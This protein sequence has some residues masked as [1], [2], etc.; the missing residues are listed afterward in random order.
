MILLFFFLVS[1]CHETVSNTLPS[2]GAGG[3]HPGTDQM[4]PCQGSAGKVQLEA[5]TANTGSFSTRAVEQEPA[6]S[7]SALRH[8]PST[9]FGKRKKLWK[10]KRAFAFE[11][12]FGCP[13]LVVKLSWCDEP[14]ENFCCKE[15]IVVC[16][17]AHNNTQI[18][19]RVP[20]STKSQ[21]GRVKKTMGLCTRNSTDAPAAGGANREELVGCDR[22]LRHVLPCSWSLPAS[23]H[24]IPT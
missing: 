23:L 6:P 8:G 21:R 12:A 11:H 19:L 24:H 3:A 5:V 10:R 7:S 9:W 15:R 22:R 14:S 2:T 1:Q 17:A 20:R 13:T 4:P 18:L 16:T